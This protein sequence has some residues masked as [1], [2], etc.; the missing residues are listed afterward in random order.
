MKVKITLTEDLLGTVPKDKEVYTTYIEGKKPPEIEESEVEDIIEAEEKGWTGFMKDEKGLYVF[1]Y[2]IKGFLKHS[3]N[4]QKDSL[5]I[6]ALRSKVTDYVFVLPRKIYFGKAEPDGIFERPRQAMT[7]QGPRTSLARSD[8]IS[9]GTELRFE[10]KMFPSHKEIT[11]KVIE[12]ILDYGQYMGL[13]QFRNGG[14]GRFSY[15]IEE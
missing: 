5:G 15:V 7:A 10:I 9:A 6:K 14:F 3:A 8:Y 4:V 2:F 12:A 11:T 1:D 13:G